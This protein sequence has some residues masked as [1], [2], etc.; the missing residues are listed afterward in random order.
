[1]NSNINER[2]NKYQQELFSGLIGT[3]RELTPAIDDSDTRFEPG[4]RTEKEYSSVE[5]S[6]S[7]DLQDNVISIS[8]IIPEEKILSRHE[9]SVTWMF[10]STQT[11]TMDGS[12]TELEGSKYFYIDEENLT[13]QRLVLS[14]LY[15]SRLPTVCRLSFFYLQLIV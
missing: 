4:F 13:M 2:D 5:D 7:N 6:R 1:M 3:M 11:P 12:G 10:G 15:V 9:R 8:V 14:Q